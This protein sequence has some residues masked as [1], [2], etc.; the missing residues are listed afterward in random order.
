MLGGCALHAVLCQIAPAWWAPDLT[1]LAL[2]TLRSGS[3]IPAMIIH[4]G[5]NALVISLSFIGMTEPSS[6][7]VWSIAIAALPLGYIGWRLADRT[8]KPAA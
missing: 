8:G 1:L 6:T 5:H 7:L 2:I 4:A 3:I